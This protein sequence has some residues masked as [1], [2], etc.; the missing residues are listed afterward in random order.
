MP[1][2]ADDPDHPI[3]VRWP[4]WAVVASVLAL[5]AL[6]YIGFHYMRGRYLIGGSAPW[7]LLTFGALSV[8]TGIVAWLVQRAARR[9]QRPS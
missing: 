7:T 8:T 9:A 1:I 2:L 4:V 6:L 5:G 3:I